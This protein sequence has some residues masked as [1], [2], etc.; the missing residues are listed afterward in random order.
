[1]YSPQLLDHFEHPRN[2]GTID[3]PDASVQLENP[4]CGD[5]LKLTLKL[6]GPR[7]ADIRFQCKGC[8]PSIACA[9]ALTELVKGKTLAEATNLTRQQLIESVGGLPEASTHASSLALD[10]LTAALKALPK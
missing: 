8:V 7:I 4:V 1:M 5:I 6:A 10:A 9:S 3:H 2:P